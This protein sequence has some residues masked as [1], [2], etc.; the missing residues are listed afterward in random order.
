MISPVTI[1]RLQEALKSIDKAINEVRPENTSAD[2]ERMISELR[3]VRNDFK[4]I[5][6]ELDN[7]CTVARF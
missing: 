5:V 7:S 6:Q 1:V 3:A 4:A 2:G